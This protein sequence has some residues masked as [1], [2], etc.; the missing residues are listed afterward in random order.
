MSAASIGNGVVRETYRGADAQTR[1]VAMASPMLKG[2][3]FSIDAAS[4]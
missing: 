4:M 3:E 1:P 2:L